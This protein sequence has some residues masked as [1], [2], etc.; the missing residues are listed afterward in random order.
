MNWVRGASLWVRHGREKQGTT[1]VVRRKLGN[2]VNRNRLRRRLRSLCLKNKKDIPPSLV[3]FCQP[4]A[5]QMAFSELEQELK[6]LLS[7]LAL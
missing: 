1:I 2:A 3:I 7:K 6:A 5:T 4:S